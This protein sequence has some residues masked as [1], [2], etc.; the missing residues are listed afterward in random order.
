MTSLVQNFD[1]S[2]HIFSKVSTPESLPHS[3]VEHRGLQEGNGENEA[4]DKTE[5]LNTPQQQ[6]QYA[7]ARKARKQVQKNC[8]ATK[9]KE[10]G[11]HTYSY[12]PAQL[13]AA[14][15]RYDLEYI[16]LV[17]GMPIGMFTKAHGPAV[18]FDKDLNVVFG[19]IE[20]PRRLVQLTNFLGVEQPPTVEK[21]KAAARQLDLSLVFFGEVA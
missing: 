11:K 12:S 6:R 18:F 14:A 17:N 2:Q 7:K 19:T 3:T 21:A 9:R 13:R 15:K 10:R 4:A 8:A 5:A 1:N 16:W 20:E